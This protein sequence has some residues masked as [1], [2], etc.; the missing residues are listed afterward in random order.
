MA[1]ITLSLPDD[2]A[3]QIRTQASRLPRI[4]KLGLRELNADA[5]P[6]F[7]GAADIFELLALLPNAEEILA[8]RP[9]PRLDAI[10]LPLRLI[11]KR[12]ECSPGFTDF[13][14]LDSDRIPSA[15]PES[16]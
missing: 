6:A 1:S 14:V 13:V 11:E 3:S 8:L 5:Q 2:L 4:L 15:T 16:V 12:E 10:T 7:D 9:A